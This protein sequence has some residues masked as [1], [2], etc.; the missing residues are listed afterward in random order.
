MRLLIVSGLS[1]SGK[2]STLHMLEDLDYYCVDNIPGRLLETLIRELGRSGPKFDLLAVGLDTRPEPEDIDR[3]S[4]LVESLRADETGCEVIFLTSSSE[5][6]LKRYSETR[7]K[8]PFSGQGLGLKQSIDFER[9]LL[10]PLCDIADLVVDT[11][12]MSVQELREAIRDRVAQRKNGQLSL[13]FESFGFKHGVPADA[14]FVFDARALPNPYWVPHLRS[15]TGKDQPVID[16]LHGDGKVGQFIED[17]TTFLERWIPEIRR[18]SRSYLTVAVGCT[19]GQH[20]SVY[21][22]ERLAQHFREHHHSVILRHTEL[23]G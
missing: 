9:K 20:R 11:S 18:G 1:G 21:V 19:G 22:A 15:L 7:R 5:V 14:D 16:F 6:L 2:S 13:Q 4:G 23:P 8:H 12:R 10:A 17:L 3:V